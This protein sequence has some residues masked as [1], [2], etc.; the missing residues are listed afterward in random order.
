M[1]D[2]EER[3]AE[4]D[5]HQRDQLGGPVDLALE[6][7]WLVDHRL[8]Q[9]R[10]PPEL[11]VHPG[12]VDHGLR[13]ATRAQ[14]ARE[15]EV[16]GLQRRGRRVRALGAARDG[17]GLAGQRRHVDLHGAGD[18]A[19]V[20]REPV[21]LGEQQQVAGHERRG[22]DL[23]ERAAAPH[24]CVG[25]QQVAKRLGRMLRLPLLREGERGVQDDHHHDRH[26]ERQHAG[27]Q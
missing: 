20:G 13:I 16:L 12:A 27:G 25:G 24:A 23:H 10:D 22:L 18:Q 7:R 19:R 5:G 17:L 2:N 15:R 4:T 9:R 3:H 26:G 14:R 1:P 21:A 8:R 11:G 6:R